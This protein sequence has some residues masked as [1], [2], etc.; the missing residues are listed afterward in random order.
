MNTR[1]IFSLLGIGMGAA[2][3]GCGWFCAK[4]K[5][6]VKAEEEI[7]KMRE[8]YIEKLDELADQVVGETPARPGKVPEKPSL[9]EIRELYSRESKL[10]TGHSES[11]QGPSENGPVEIEEDG[12]IIELTQEELEDEDIRQ[13][14]QQALYMNSRPKLIRSEDFGEIPTFEEKSLLYYQEDDTLTTDDDELVEDRNAMVGEC[15]S[16]FGFEDN[17]EKTIWVRNYEYETDYEIIK[18]FGAFGDMM[19]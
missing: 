12:E 2:C 7:K 8:Y 19:Q 6:E 5:Y 11:V 16:Q 15:L 17:D 9:D 18:V 3:F 1:L 4:T 13:K 10:D 14:E